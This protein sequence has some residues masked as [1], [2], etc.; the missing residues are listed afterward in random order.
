MNKMPLAI[1]VAFAW[2]VLLATGVVVM[3][4]GNV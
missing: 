3:A 4:G 1:K 2:L